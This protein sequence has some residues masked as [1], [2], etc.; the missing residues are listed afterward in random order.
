MGIFLKYFGK[1][2]ANRP[3]KEGIGSESHPEC[4][5]EGKGMDDIAERAEFNQQN[6]PVGV[7]SRGK[8]HR[9]IISGGK[10]ENE[11][12]FANL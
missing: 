12:Q 9:P 8:W 4:L 5:E 3:T 1:F 2:R 11:V 6:T 7:R 10:E